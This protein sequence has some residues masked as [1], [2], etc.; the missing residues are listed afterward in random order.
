MPV[1]GSGRATPAGVSWLWGSSGGAG[2]SITTVAIVVGG[3]AVMVVEVV[4]TGTVVLVI[5][6]EF[7]VLFTLISP[8]SSGSS[9]STGREASGPEHDVSAPV[10]RTATIA[11][12]VTALTVP[13]TSGGW[14]APSHPC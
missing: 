12:L 2:G 6:E 5:N 3:G 1:D 9:S 10:N 11:S 14:L 4:V 8:F 13:E 7:M